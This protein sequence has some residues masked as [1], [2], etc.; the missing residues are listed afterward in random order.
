KL[1]HPTAPRLVQRPATGRERL[2]VDPLLPEDGED[3]LER[4]AI[5][6]AFREVVDGGSQDRAGPLEAERARELPRL[7][8]EE[9][10]SAALT[11]V[12]QRRSEEH[13]S[14]HLALPAL[15]DH[16]EEDRLRLGDIARPDR[17]EERPPEMR[18]LARH[19]ERRFRRGRRLRL[20]RGIG[21]RLEDRKW[22]EPRFHHR[23][24]IRRRAK[25][26]EAPWRDPG[27]T[28]IMQGDAAG[29][30]ADEF[31]WRGLGAAVLDGRLDGGGPGGAR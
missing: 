17:K 26:R 14:G 6:P 20:V 11:H 15:I 30:G 9:Q 19:D 25:N 18:D 12:L 7:D 21:D 31:E 10:L 8:R 4:G 2:E 16:P 23:G 28:I 5:P 1:W 27:R 24:E 29:R 22:L 3:C 13:V